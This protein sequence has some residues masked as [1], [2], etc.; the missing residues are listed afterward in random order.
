VIVTRVFPGSPLTVD[1]EETGARAQIVELYRP[2]R[3]PFVRINL[4]SSVSGSA[5]GTDGTSETLSNPVDRTIL[6]VIREHGDV[7]VIGAQSLRAEGYLL[8]RRV[9]LAV[10]TS[11]GNLA[12]HGTGPTGATGNVIVV[13]PP[14]AVDRVHETS[15]DMSIEILTVDAPDGRLAIAD[16]IEAL[17]AR[18]LTSIVCEGGPGLAAQ[19]L[20]AGVVDEVCLS[21]SPVIN[22]SALPVFGTDDTDQ[23]ALRIDQL[24]VDEA[25]GIYARWGVI[26]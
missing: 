24:M 8:P 26:R 9:P 3:E 23:T 12:G 18:G 10:V 2:S 7:V 16:I 1:L 13:C 14:S 15:G 5:G 21:T 17:A 6:G 19:F 11:S 25:S 20:E 4:I 22:G